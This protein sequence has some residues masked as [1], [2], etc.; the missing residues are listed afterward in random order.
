MGPQR[1]FS[2]QAATFLGDH[3]PRQDYSS[4]QRPSI[5]V[6]ARPLAAAAPRN[7]S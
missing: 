2:R 3:C 4:Q 7:N 6:A 5:H 1:A